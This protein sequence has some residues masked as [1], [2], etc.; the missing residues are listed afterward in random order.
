MFYIN[1]DS[2]QPDRGLCGA[3]LQPPGEERGARRERPE[4]TGKRNEWKGGTGAVT[5]GEVD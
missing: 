5:K 3:L 4:E 2:I 1:C